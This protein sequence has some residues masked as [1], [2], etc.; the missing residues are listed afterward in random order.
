MNVISHGRAGAAL[1]I[2]QGLDRLHPGG[3]DYETA[4]KA[5]TLVFSG[6]RR[7]DAFLLRNVLRDA[8]R[9][10]ARARS[11]IP[12]RV[13]LD[14]AELHDSGYSPEDHLVAFE[15]L[16]VVESIVANDLPSDARRCLPGLLREETI[17]ESTA[18][19]GIPMRRVKYLRDRIRASVA[20][21]LGVASYLASSSNGVRRPPR[22][23][24]QKQKENRP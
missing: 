11:R 17:E 9:A 6:D 13:D 5:L 2:Y 22:R 1:R 15:L 7:E 23:R 12:D 21:A 20:S 4:E 18:D 14:T 8:R 3:D 16:A 19:T 10:R 24:A